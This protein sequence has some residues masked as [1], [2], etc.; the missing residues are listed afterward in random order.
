MALDTL[1]FKPVKDSENPNGVRVALGPGCQARCVCII[2]V[3]YL[4]SSVELDFIKRG[5]SS[6]K[7]RLGKKVC[8]C[9]GGVLNT[10]P[11]FPFPFLKCK[12]HV[13]KLGA[14]GHNRWFCTQLPTE[15]RFLG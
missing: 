15:Q 4:L 2:E 7:P 12:C 14:G 9:I 11:P 1:P 6:P 5:V 10:P 3:A 13:C 8:V